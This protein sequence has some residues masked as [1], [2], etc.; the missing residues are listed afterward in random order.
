[1]I[2]SIR[3][4]KWIIAVIT[5]SVF[6]FVLWNCA[7]FAQFPTELRNFPA[8]VSSSLSRGDTREKV[9]SVLGEPL[10]DA[11]KLNVQVY[12]HSASDITFDIALPFIPF[13]TPDV[14]VFSLVTYDENGLVK[15]LEVML[16]ETNSGR[17][18]DDIYLDAGDFSLINIKGSIPETLLGASI[19]WKEL[20]QTTAPK[21]GCAL[22]ILMGECPMSKVLLDKT[23]IVDLHPAGFYC[24]PE[25]QQ[26]ERRKHKLYRTFVKRDI[27]PGKHLMEMRVKGARELEAIFECKYGETI[28]AEINAKSYSDKGFWHGMHLEGIILLHTKPP[29]SLVEMGELRPILWNR[30]TWYGAPGLLREH[31]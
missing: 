19:P 23:P 20:V 11:S 8:E 3:V 25:L 6:I 21:E 29:K 22:V 28:Y 7:T 5:F 1:M 10:V 27:K 12:Q 30:D 9:H 15:D 24:N 16:L 17:F 31:N 26:S 14:Y 2:V 4:V 13:W 18:S